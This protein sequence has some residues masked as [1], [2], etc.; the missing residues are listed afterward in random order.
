VW[1][2]LE[3]L[4][5]GAFPPRAARALESFRDLIVGLQ[6]DA[7][8]LPLPALLDRL[9]EATGYAKLYRPEDAEDQARLE[10]LRE[11]LSAAQEFTERR[12]AEGEEDL[13]TAFLDHVALVSDLD[14]WQADRGLALMTL[15]S[16]KGLEFPVV[17]VAGLEEGLLPHY[18]AGGR[19]EDVEEERRLL[20]VGMTRARERLL[21][22][23]CRRRR[24]AGRYQPQ[25]ESR[26]LAEI[27][28]ELVEATQSP[29]LFWS[30]RT[31]PVYAFFGDGDEGQ[32]ETVATRRPRAGSRVRHPT[33]GQGVILELEG[34][35]DDLKLTVYFERAG[36]K[37]LL[38]R[39]ASLELL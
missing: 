19:P 12:T 9:L 20:Y 26:F 24:I 29:T 18:N 6:R 5:V 16:A 30:E 37:K 28:A 10:N 36:K 34:E 7:D 17:V 22:S 1:D 11:F 2:V 3:H 14:T 33:L 13:L 15:H 31:R 27:P 8:E 38:A 39:Y 21:L 32:A 4:E 25:L 35:G 23:C